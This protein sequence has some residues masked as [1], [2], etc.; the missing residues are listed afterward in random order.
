M[1]ADSLSADEKHDWRIIRKNLEEIGITVTA[2]NENKDF[3]I[4]WFLDAIAIGAFNEEASDDEPIT[5]SSEGVISGIRENNQHPSELN[6]VT[7]FTPAAA[8]K[9]SKSGT[10]KTK[11][12]A[13][14]TRRKG[15]APKSHVPRFAAMM[16]VLSRPQSS[17]INA[18]SQKN[19]SQARAILNDNAKASM[20][21]LVEALYVSVR[22]KNEEMTRVVLEKGCDI[23]IRLNF[24]EETALLVAVGGEDERIVRLLLQRGCD[25]NARDRRGNT[26]LIT[27][28][29]K[30]NEQISLL[31]LKKG[32][33]VNAENSNGN[34]AL[35][36]AVRNNNEQIVRALLEKGDINVEGLVT[37]ANNGNEQIVRLLLHKG[38]DVNARDNTGNFALYSAA[39]AGHLRTVRLLLEKGADANARKSGAY[40]TALSIAEFRKHE[41]VIKFL[42]QKGATADARNSALLISSVKLGKDQ[43]VEMLIE[44]GLDPNTPGPSGELALHEAVAAR[45]SET[46]HLLLEMGANAN[47]RSVNSPVAVLDMAIRET[48][49][50]ISANLTKQQREDE[51]KSR[52]EMVDMLVLGGAAV[53]PSVKSHVDLLFSASKDGNDQ[54]AGA[55]LRG[56]MDAN[57]IGSAGNPVLHPAVRSGNV[58]L[59]RLLLE[60]SADIIF[61]DVFSE[62]SALDIAKTSGNEE[63]VQLLVEKGAKPSIRREP[64]VSNKVGSNTDKKRSKRSSRKA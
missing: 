59:V 57:A 6:N 37:A 40:D 17:F 14:P 31:L 46:V 23:D 36:T 4:N 39:D 19:Y 24:R 45:K 8:V 55:L 5:G 30:D 2:F 53:S 44:N 7:A 47:I 51:Q 22:Q 63:I 50:K 41:Q 9:P 28:V 18:M 35:N 49:N 43:L 16:A 58:Q 29:R 62:N 61:Q 60:N 64:K 21:D 42:L 32:C 33:G 25:V 10:Q 34:T 48:D 15:V 13:V 52:R 3:I 12:Q 27:A 20:L 54:I 1:T 56:G 38:A 26:A 11:S